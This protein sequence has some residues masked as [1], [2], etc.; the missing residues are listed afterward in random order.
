MS[1]NDIIDDDE[2]DTDNMEYGF[3]IEVFFNDGKTTGFFII[4]KDMDAV[5]EMFKTAFTKGY[6]IIGDSED[7][8]IVF[9]HNVKY[10]RF[11]KCCN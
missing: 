1:I 9:I 8:K 11:T 3:D 4:S 6:F 2:I 10:L 5:H 7:S